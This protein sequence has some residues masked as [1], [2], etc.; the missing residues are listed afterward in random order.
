MAILSKFQ[1][2]EAIILD[3]LRLTEV[4]TKQVADILKALK[5]KGTT[6][7]IGIAG[8][9]P[10]VYKSARNIEGVVVHPAKEFNAYTVLRQKRL[11]LTRAALDE[12]RQNKPAPATAQTK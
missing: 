4:K 2:K 5:L 9:D 7:L 6:C 12:L 11:V 1:D 10:V 8:R 3:D